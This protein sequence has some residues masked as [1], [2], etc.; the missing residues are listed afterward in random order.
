MKGVLGS[1]QT[2]GRFYSGLFD[3]LEL[4]HQAAFALT[5]PD[6]EQEQNP[7]MCFINTCLATY[8]IVHQVMG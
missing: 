3:C 2:A 5:G 1:S 6:A 8:T 7:Q 4:K